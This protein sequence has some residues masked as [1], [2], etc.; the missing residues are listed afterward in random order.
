MVG[1]E[2][3]VSL[4]LFRPKTLHQLLLLLEFDIARQQG[5]AP[6][7]ADA[8]HTAAGIGVVCGQRRSRCRVQHVEAHT[9]PCPVLP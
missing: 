2:Q 9:V 8:Q 6:P 7:V 4:Q 1:C 3:H 5:T